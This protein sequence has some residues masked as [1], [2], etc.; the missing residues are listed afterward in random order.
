M[1]FV[2]LVNILAEN[3]AIPKDCIKLIVFPHIPIRVLHVLQAVSDKKAVSLKTMQRSIHLPD[4]VTSHHFVG[5][6]K[7][8]VYHHGTHMIGKHR[9]AS[10]QPSVCIRLPLKDCLYGLHVVFGNY[11][12]VVATAQPHAESQSHNT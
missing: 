4:V 10:F 8:R 12:Q 5:S 7:S 9:I 2:Y 11:V 3:I 6:T 1:N